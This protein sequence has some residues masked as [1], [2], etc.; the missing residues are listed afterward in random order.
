M[1]L[2]NFTRG[3]GVG[4]G[5]FALAIMLSNNWIY[6]NHG[7]AIS[8][9]VC[10]SGMTGALLSSTFSAW[11]SAY[12]WHIAYLM[13]AVVITVFY[14]ISNFLPYTLTPEESGLKPYGYELSEKREIKKVFEQ[15]TRN[16]FWKIF[17]LFVVYTCV[18]SLIAGLVQHLPGVAITKELK[19]LLVH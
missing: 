16:I 15:D 5:S 11:I 18:I 10:F 4:I 8:I 1:C 2:W 6:A 14:S 19:L 12:G 13:I 7:L 9:V 17:A 3:I